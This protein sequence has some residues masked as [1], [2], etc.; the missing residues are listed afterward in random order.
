MAERDEESGV[1]L[2]QEIRADPAL[3][4]LWAKADDALR[5]SIGLSGSTWVRPKLNEA[6][7][8]LEIS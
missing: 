1:K 6:R 2:A 7:E 8:I 4:E 5:V 3:A